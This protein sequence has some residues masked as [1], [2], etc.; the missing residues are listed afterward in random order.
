VTVST[1]L[2]FSGGTLQTTGVL[3]T[4]NNLSELTATAS[5]ARSNLGLVIGTDVQAFDDDLQAIAALTGTNTIYY[6]SAANTW[7][8]V[9]I[10]T[11]LSFSGGTL[12]AS[13]GS[14]ITSLGG[15]T[16]STQTFATGTSGTDFAI[17][18]ATNTH[19]FNLPDAGASARG[20]VTTG[21]QTFAGDKTFTGVLAG[22]GNIFSNNSGGT[23]SIGI[24][25][26][27]GGG[28]R[29]QML[30]G[31]GFML[32]S[33]YSV[34]WSPNST[35][36]NTPDLIL[37]RDAAGTLSQRNGTNAQTFRLENTFTSTTN[38][39]YFQQSWVSN[40]MQMGTAVGSAGG[41]IRDISIGTWNAAGTRYPGLVVGVASNSGEY[42]LWYGAGTTST[43]AV[44]LRVSGVTNYLYFGSNLVIAGGTSNNNIVNMYSPVTF[45]ANAQS[46]GALTD[47]TY[48]APSHTGQTAST[49]APSIYLNLTNSKTW[50]TGSLT[51]Q[52]FIRI[53][54]PT[55]AFAGASTV[56]S[57]ATLSIAGAPI[58]GTNAT[59]TNSY[60][61]WVEA[62]MSQFGGI[63]NT[64]AALVLNTGSQAFN[65]SYHFVNWNGASVGWSSAGT[66]NS[67]S[68]LDTAFKR[69]S[70]GLIEINNGTAGTYR[71]LVLRNLRMSAPT[72]PATSSD[73]GSEGQVSWDSNYIYV[74]TATNTWKRAALATF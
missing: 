7:T 32:A 50:A 30:Y 65:T 17:S 12:S 51:T 33:T 24:R 42:L 8:A 63:I 18:S 36:T 4:A 71:D 55:I 34:T 38:R 72:V 2:S 1:G 11:G 43:N 3:L 56:A 37:Q 68:T 6:R 31:T 66:V 25:N 26:G 21:T 40:E 64:T 73:T 49:E 22:D 14:G 15:Q 59:I 61:L 58:A 46:S 45:V 19:T 5:T 13:G 74:C 70:A 20:V 53:T 39:E 9:S 52:R 27:A 57:A 29:I 60:A 28:N 62:G 67:T 44:K 10:G 47:F 41:S 69:V 16:G 48:T 54:A 23:S 35:N